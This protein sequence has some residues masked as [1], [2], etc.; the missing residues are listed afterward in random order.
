MEAE[1]WLY[2]EPARTLSS[3]NIGG[4][5]PQA[6]KKDLEGNTVAES[7]FVQDYLFTRTI[8]ILDTTLEKIIP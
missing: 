2:R 7:M 6:Q 8:V 3:E 4:E 1:V 5:Y